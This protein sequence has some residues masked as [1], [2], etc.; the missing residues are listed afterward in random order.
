MVRFK[1]EI[2]AV[3][4]RR[5]RDVD[6]AG[7]LRGAEAGEEVCDAREGLGGGEVLSLQGGVFC[8]IFFGRAGELGPF[9]ED[10]G[11]GG[12]GAALQL[13]FDGPGEGGAGVFGEE[14][15]GAEGVEVFGVEEEAVH[16]EETGAD[17]GWGG[18]CGCLL[19]CV[20]V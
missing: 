13:G 3:R 7:F 8:L 10:S 2:R 6:I 12:A 16:V 4:R 15:V 18:H 14:D 17:G 5:E 9:V 1:L 19:F 20:L 11:G